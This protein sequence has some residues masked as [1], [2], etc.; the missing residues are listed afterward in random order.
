MTQVVKFRQRRRYGK[1][2]WLLSSL[3][4]LTVLSLLWS[5]GK[6]SDDVG[7]PSTPV[8][9]T[10]GTSHDVSVTD[11]IGTYTLSLSASPNSI[12]ADSTNYSILSAVLSDKS[13][14]SVKGYPIVFSTSG[15][16][17][18]FY[19]PVTG[20][21]LPTDTSFTDAKGT[22]STRLYGSQSGRLVVTATV[23]LDDDGTADLRDAVAVNLTASGPPDSA[24]SYSIRVWTNPTTT[25]ADAST[26]VA[27]SAQI[28][29]SRGGPVENFKIDFTAESGYL[30]NDINT[31]G[32]STSAS[33]VT[34][35]SGRV[36]LWYFGQTP[37]SDVITATTFIS[38]L[39][40]KLSDTTVIMVTGSTPITG[41]PT[42]KLFTSPSDA[43]FTTADSGTITAKVFGSNGAALQGV[44]VYFS[45]TLG[46]VSPS[47]VETDAS[48]IAS[49]TLTSSV[50]GTATV[51]ATVNYSGGS[52]NELVTFKIAAGV[53]KISVAVPSTTLTLGTN[54]ETSSTITA[55]ATLQDKEGH[56]VEGVQV[57]FSV[58]ENCSNVS[59]SPQSYSSVS[60]A[61]GYASYEITVT[62]TAVGSCQYTVRAAS[63]SS[64][65]MASGVITINN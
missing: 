49:T 35:A 53:E 51:Y 13:G 4:C 19:E 32:P 50:P 61:G 46:T 23:D 30:S 25:P 62:G 31:I 10:G 20:I 36:S 64:E 40:G 56:F 26:P 14:R 9:T 39:I 60:D 18:W 27:V 57:S 65:D 11:K 24:G 41:M 21:L 29:D 5:C 48:G 55:S 22:A 34:N 63:G 47:S 12:P 58:S 3:I 17:G 45:T 52:V 28:S 2:S 38:D 44:T 7:Q 54:T 37:G 15:N 43:S 33:A 42:L 8:G 59:F 6:L 16:I 1:C